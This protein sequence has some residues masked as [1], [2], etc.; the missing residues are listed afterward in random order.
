MDEAASVSLTATKGKITIAT[1]AVKLTGAGKR[2]QTLKLTG[3]GRKALK[4][5]TRAAIKVTARAVDPAGNVGSATA[6]KTL[7]C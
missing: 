3:A 6:G 1:G 2:V 5:E 4:R 7:R